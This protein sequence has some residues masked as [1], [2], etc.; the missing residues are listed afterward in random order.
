MRVALLGAGR[1]GRLHAR[2]LRATAGV[3]RVVIADAD[4]ARAAE[5]AQPRSGIEAAS[6]VEAA[7]DAADAVVIAA[8][9]TRPHRR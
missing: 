4:P 1:I 5:V 7:L 3:D 8:A 2:L 6:D 9:T